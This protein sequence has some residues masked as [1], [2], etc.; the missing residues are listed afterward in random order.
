MKKSVVRECTDNAAIIDAT[1]NEGE[2]AEAERHVV[3]AA[4]ESLDAAADELTETVEAEDVLTPS[5]RSRKPNWL[6]TW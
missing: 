1:G 5:Y 4:F 2:I 3:V 6:H